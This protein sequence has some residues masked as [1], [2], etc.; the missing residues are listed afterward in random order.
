MHEINPVSQSHPSN[1][2]TNSVSQPK[3]KFSEK[4]KNFA[5][6]IGSLTKITF[7]VIVGFSLL[8]FVGV[9]FASA[10]ESSLA[11]N[12]LMG[13]GDAKIAVIN[14]KGT[15]FDESES[16]PLDLTSSSVVTP[17]QIFKVL[18]NIKKDDAVKAV[19]LR[20]NS[21]GGTTTASEEIYQML[22]KYKK[23]TG[24]P[25]Y[26][27]F[28]EMAASGAYYISM[29]A[30]ELIAN[31][32]SLTGSIGVIV[33]SVNYSELAN[34]YGVKDVTIKSGKNKD[35]LN[36]LAPTNEEQLKIMQDIVDET[37]Q[38]FLSRVRENRNIPQD[39]LERLADGRVLSG[40]QA[41]DNGFVDKVGTFLDAVDIVR[42][43]IGAPDAKVIEY[44]SGALLSGILNSVLRKSTVELSIF[45]SN[46]K[47]GLSGKIAYIY[48]P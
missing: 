11:E 2:S 26:A 22:V 31:P 37:Y 40:L 33:N 43:D 42:K 4:L 45:P 23:E 17:T 28:G 35:L 48:L 34:K 13:Q 20:V 39:T 9:F 27:S 15:I 29:A 21:P 1:I 44:R 41:R 47:A 12:V 38:L 5:S 10:E 6:V 14:I 30:D 7:Y 24:V 3:T 25:I 46:I 19:I 16:S 32:S 8:S 18:E 36:P